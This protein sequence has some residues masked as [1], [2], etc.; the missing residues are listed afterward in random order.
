MGLCRGEECPEFTDLWDLAD[1]LE[2][3]IDE[4]ESMSAGGPPV[5]VG[6]WASRFDERLNA[7]IEQR[8]KKT[9]IRKSS[10]SSGETPSSRNSP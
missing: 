7:L 8:R 3:F 9:C 1:M 4:H 6:K 5:D 2:K 10:P